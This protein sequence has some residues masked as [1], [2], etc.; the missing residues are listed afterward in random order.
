MF[1]S[2]CKQKENLN[3]KK[4]QQNEWIVSFNYSLYSNNAF[5][6]IPAILEVLTE[7]SITFRKTQQPVWKAVTKFKI[8][9][10]FVCNFVR[11]IH[12]HNKFTMVIELHHRICVLLH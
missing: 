5:S 10:D 2:I 11:K 12:V 3:T 8:G 7:Q 6:F 1:H 4:W 9:D